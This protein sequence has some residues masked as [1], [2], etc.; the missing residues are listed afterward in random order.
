MRLRLYDAR[1]SEL[2]ASNGLCATDVASVANLVNRCQRR[3]LYARES[4]DEGWYGTF[5]E[6]L[7]SGISRT[8]PFV[9]CSRSIARIEALTVCHQVVP[10]Q[11][12]FYEYLTFGNGRM[13]RL[14]PCDNYGVMNAYGRNNAVTFAS[15]PNTPQAIRIY[16]S[17]PND[18]ASGFRV[19]LQ[20]FDQN[21]AVI[22]SQDGEN[23][24]QGEYLYL[25]SPF[26]TSVNL[27]SNQLQGIQKDTTQGVLSFFTVDPATGDETLIHTMEPGEQVASYRRY[28]LN[29][30]P[31]NCC[32]TGVSAND[33][34]VTNATLQIKAIC[35]LELIPAV[36]DQDWLLLQ[37]LEALIEEAKSIHFS[38][39]EDATSKGQ[40]VIHHTN[41]IRLLNGELRH[42]YGKD[43]PA[44]QFRPFGSARL[45]RLNVGMM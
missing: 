25:A 31:A 37:N 28:Y 14:W 5:A 32:S 38:D 7:F 42:Y 29:N 27:F 8:S 24:V 40:A 9:T 44:I 1:I 34:S 36:C 33:C 23:Q 10:V 3:L 17:D 12:P 22:Y 41:A 26:V 2:P 19:L 18:A 15:K 39:M 20:G 16:S 4:G 43:E 45:E 35:K 30:L 11:N 13:P 21:N 6:I